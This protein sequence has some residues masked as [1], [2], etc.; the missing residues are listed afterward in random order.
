MTGSLQRLPLGISDFAKLREASP[1]YLYVDKTDR[2]LRVLNAG[3]YLFLARPR[4]FGKS[5]LCSTIEYLYAGRRDLFRGLAIEPMWDWSKTNPVLHFSLALA[6]STTP[7]ILRESLLN[8]LHMA[9]SDQGLPSMNTGLS[10]SFGALLKGIHEKTGRR[11]VVIIDE[12]EKPVHDHIQDVVL[13]GLFRDVLC[14]FYGALKSCD[15]HIEKLFITGVGRMVRTSVF[16]QLNQIKDLTLHE[17]AAEICGYTETELKDYFTPFIPPLA[18]KND[19]TESA[20]WNK[21]RERYN[22]YWW[23]KG[24]RVYNPWAILNCLAD[25]EFGNFWWVSGTPRVLTTFAETTQ[26]SIPE[27]PNGTEIAELSLLIDLSNLQPIPLLWQTGYLTIL[28]VHG[29]TFT[30][31]FP[32]AE[33]REAWFGMM[34]DRFRKPGE[35]TDGVTTAGILLR[36]LTEGDRPRFETALT[37]LFAS[38]PGELHVEREAYY[39]SVFITALQGGGGRLIPE[40]RSDKGRADAILETKNTVYVIEFKLGK[41]SDAL[42]QIKE[43]RYYEPYLADGRKLIMLG[44]GGFQGKQIQC[45]WEELQGKDR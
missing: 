45:L 16:S 13:A 1:A 9:A 7:D 42:A 36:S 6:D 22:G 23:G 2:L 18:S 31:G 12:Y 26:Q 20:A 30:L 44:A 43:K 4:R 17:V 34:L 24:E 3:D 35:S 27:D 21:L 28:K 14:T 19:L 5:L 40:S 32:N 41:A 11:V 37:A 38:L 33:V 8:L 15:K 25:S 39:H 10:M 29:Q